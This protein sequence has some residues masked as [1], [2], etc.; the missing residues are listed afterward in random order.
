MTRKA[1]ISD[2]RSKLS[3]VKRAL[4]EKRLP[5]ALTSHSK[6]QVI[7]RRPEPDLVPL[8]FVQERLWFLDQLEPGKPCLQLSSS[9]P[10]HRPAQ[11][12]E[13]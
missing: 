10:P 5:D 6:S 2:R 13:V 4:L 9:P 12:M 7:P 3:P 11:F 8:S 1:D